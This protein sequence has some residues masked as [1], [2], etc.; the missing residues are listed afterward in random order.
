ME[1]ASGALA[2]VLLG[3]NYPKIQANMQHSQLLTEAAKANQLETE[4]IHVKQEEYAA[5]AQ[6]ADNRYKD[7]AHLILS[8]GFDGKYTAISEGQP[9]IKGEYAETYR[10]K[11]SDPN[12]DWST[13]PDSH[14]LPA[15][16]I[17][18]DAYGMTAELVSEGGK[19]AVARYLARTGN[20]EVI[21]AA[22]DR[23]GIDA[24]AEPLIQ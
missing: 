11:T 17:I 23:S 9:V 18:G 15:G 16:T 1:L 13:V 20:R 5:R 6:V 22:I 7:N 4:L 19:V 8:L 14:Y 3:F 10:I 24:I 2:L 12:F 21:Q